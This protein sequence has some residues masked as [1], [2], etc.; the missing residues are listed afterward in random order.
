M[1]S[2]MKY[3]III[4]LLALCN[5]TCESFPTENKVTSSVTIFV[6]EGSGPVV[7]AKIIIQPLTESWTSDEN[8]RALISGLETKNYS[9]TVE[10]P[11]GLHLTKWLTIA[12]SMEFT[13]TFSCGSLAINVFDGHG[14]PVPDATITTT[15][16]TRE[17]ISDESGRA[18][19]DAVFA[20]NYAVSVVFQDRIVFS[21]NVEVAT[22]SLSEINCSIYGDLSLV[23]KNTEGNPLSDAVITSSP[24]TET[25]STDLSGSVH[26]KDA[27]T[28]DYEFTV[29]KNDITLL[30]APIVITA[31]ETEM[32]DLVY[33]DQAPEVFI[34]SPESNQLARQPFNLEG[35]SADFEDGELSGDNLVWSSDISGEIGRGNEVT[36]NNLSLGWHNI[37]LEA[38]DSDGITGIAVIR[39]NVVPEDMYG[40]YFPII[41]SASWTYKHSQRV[42]E[43]PD[44]LGEIVEWELENIIVGVLNDGWRETR[45]EYTSK[46]NRTNKEYTYIVRDKIIHEGGDV[47]VTETEE[48]MSMDQGLTENSFQITTEYSSPFLLIQGHRELTPG[49]E[50][51]NDML[52]SLHWHENLKHDAFTE[53]FN[54]Y[55]KT[56]IGEEKIVRTPLGQMKAKPLTIV[57]DGSFRTWWLVKGIGIVKMEYNMFDPHPVAEL[58]RSSLIGAGRAAP[59]TSSPVPHAVS[60]NSTKLSTAPA[61][62]DIRTL[63]EL[64]HM[65]IPR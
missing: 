49:T 6:N 5:V 38:S 48:F 11:N 30:I 55:S 8:G 17:I 24:P 15:P 18:L 19:L 57:S 31:D 7:G 52:I 42:F 23:V 50:F 43:I 44:D 4:V 36:C 39:V 41:L 21:D 28:G 33:S 51:V 35:Y 34:V 40:S 9:V 10:H 45:I 29:S 2:K 54:I 25:V 58:Y 56:S 12:N 47:Y 59:E 53:H 64:S 13:F 14:N 60:F 26:I 32:I 16:V 1:S 3:L 65:L 63:R 62:H 22:D 61:P 27:L 20:S 37:R 46:K